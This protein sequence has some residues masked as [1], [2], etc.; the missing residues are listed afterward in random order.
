MPKSATATPRPSTGRRVLVTGGA[1]FIGSHLVDRLL[2]QGH[3]VVVYDDFST[4]F[5]RFLADAG[6]AGCR[7]VKGNLLDC[8]RLRRALDG[9]DLVAHL[10]ANADVR[11]GLDRP[12]LDLE[13]NTRATSVLLEAMR[14][15]G[16][17]RL[18]FS[19]TGAIYGEPSVFPTPE[20]AP[21]PL[22]TSL[23]GAS[24]LAAEGLI[25]AYCHGF[26]LRAWIFRFVSILGPRY[27]HGHVF[28]FVRKLRADP[29]T[30]DVL[31]D[32]RQRKSYLHVDDCIAGML[33]A[34]GDEPDPV[35]V[36]NLGHDA[37][38]VV[39]E[40]LDWICHRLGVE[41]ERRYAGGA[42]G[43]VGD[44]P[45]VELD[46]TRMRALGWAPTR[47]IRASV[48]STVDY[49]VAEPWLLDARR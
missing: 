41:P 16:V 12:T 32:G 22:Q 49:L 1:G 7:I 13:Q 15:A 39:D 44:S 10:A 45:R 23:Y 37:S 43:W 20:D 5:R 21:L 6:H 33:R 17:D 18:L 47:S 36:Y 35:A 19:S 48:E 11:G 25:S 14:A 40:S 27:S 38:C 46:C 2:A 29:S 8:E 24:K 31:G 26:G 3:E 34:L 30:I 4:G 28:D 42:R 9:C